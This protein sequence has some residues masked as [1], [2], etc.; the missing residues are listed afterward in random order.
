MI[1][2]I[3]QREWSLKII[4]ALGAP[5]LCPGRKAAR[6]ETSK[7]MVRILQESKANHFDGITTSHEFWF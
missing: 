7:E 1:K 5:F 3:L 2:T 6:D 4:T